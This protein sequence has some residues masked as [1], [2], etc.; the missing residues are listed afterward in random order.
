MD[1]SLLLQKRSRSGDPLRAIA[2]YS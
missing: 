2:A 1:R